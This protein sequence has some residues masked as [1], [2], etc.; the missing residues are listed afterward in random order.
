MTP[1]YRFSIMNNPKKVF[2]FYSSMSVLC[3]DSHQNIIA[4]TLFSAMNNHEKFLQQYLSSL[5]W[6]TSKSFHVA[7]SWFS[8]VLY[9]EWSQQ[10]IF[11]NI[12]VLCTDW[13]QNVI[14]VTWLS[15]MN[16]PNMFLIEV[17]QQ[18]RGSI[19]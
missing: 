16:D 19:Q 14:A 1:A 3:A 17:S 10:V 2:F 12:L 9:N 4:V 18:H 13:P 5:K 7:A 8:T 6:M 15:V 11:S